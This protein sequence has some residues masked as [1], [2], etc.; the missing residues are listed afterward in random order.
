MPRIK[1]IAQTNECTTY[2]AVELPKRIKLTDSELAIV[3]RLVRLLRQ[4]DHWLGAYIEWLLETDTEQTDSVSVDTAMK[5]LEDIKGLNSWARWFEESPRKSATILR[6]YGHR[7]FPDHVDRLMADVYGG[8]DPEFCNLVKMWR[9]E[10]SEP[11]K[12]QQP[13]TGRLGR[14]N[15]D[16]DDD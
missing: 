13:P 16:E 2:P 11:A 14:D 8:D 15:E 6:Y 12:P 10:H 9:V 3:A 4:R 1:S 5:M 7:F